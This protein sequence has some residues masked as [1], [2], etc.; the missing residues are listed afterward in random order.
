MV[1]THAL[2]PDA[3]RPSSITSI[4]F[5]CLATHSCI[6]KSSICRKYFFDLNSELDTLL[7]M[8]SPFLSVMYRS[9]LRTFFAKMST[10]LSMPSSSFLEYE[11]NIRRIRLCKPI[12]LV[13]SSSTSSIIS[14][15]PRASFNM[16]FSL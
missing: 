12:D 2:L 7:F 15:N 16:S 1:R 6:F 4:F 11:S 3:S 14:S 13:R 8:M 5:L 9:F 10:V